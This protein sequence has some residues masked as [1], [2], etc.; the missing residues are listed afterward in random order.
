[1]VVSFDGRMLC[2]PIFRGEWLYLE[3]VA[4]ISSDS[5]RK[6][7][8]TPSGRSFRTALSQLPVQGGEQH[9]DRV[10][11]LCDCLLHSSCRNRVRFEKYGLR[12][13]R[14]NKFSWGMRTLPIDH[15]RGR[16][17]L[18]AHNGKIGGCAHSRCIGRHLLYASVHWPCSDRLS[19]ADGIPGFCL[20]AACIWLVPCDRARAA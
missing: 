6:I 10:R 4:T 11:N 13:F 8:R 20:H 14:R 2:H 16:E 15:H 1:M 7:L 9:L 12:L 3:N 5:L 17:V 18:P 19:V